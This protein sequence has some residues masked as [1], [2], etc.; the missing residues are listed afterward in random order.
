MR[1][2]FTF[3][4]IAYRLGNLPRIRAIVSTDLFAVFSVAGTVFA[5]YAGYH[6]LLIYILLFATVIACYG[7]SRT[8][9]FIFGNPVVYFLGTISFSIYL[10]HMLL[11]PAVE[12]VEGFSVAHFGGLSG[13]FSVAVLF[14]C[15]LVLA[16]A[17]YYLIEVPGKRL[18]M[19]LMLHKEQ[20]DT[21]RS[22]A[23]GEGIDVA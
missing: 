23:T 3:G 11:H 19:S 12:R 21:K 13:V 4:L 14:F 15:V 7:N 2:G 9:N 18:M 5:F 20:K 8:A 17:S 6:D 16:T 1:G 10:V 22:P